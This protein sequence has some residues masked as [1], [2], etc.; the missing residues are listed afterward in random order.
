MPPVL[1]PVRSKVDGL[2]FLGLSLARRS[3]VG[4]P[5]SK[6]HQVAFDLNE[7]QDRDYNYVFS[8]NDDGWLV[9]GGEPGPPYSYKLPA[10]DSAHVE[11]M[12]IGTFNRSW[13]GVPVEEIVDVFKNSKILIPE[14]T[15]VPTAVIEND[16]FPPELE[17]RFDMERA[18]DSYDAVSELPPLPVNWQLRF[19]HNQ[20][21]RIF[22]FPSRFC[23]GPF[24]STIL[25][26]TE[27]RSENHREQYFEK[28]RLAVDRWM[29]DGP[30]PL[31]V[32]GDQ[33]MTIDANIER[34]KCPKKVV[35]GGELGSSDEFI[36]GLW[37]FS[38][39]DHVTH[40]FE[41]NFLPPYDTPAKR[42]VILDVL[43]EEWDEKTLSWKSC[44]VP[45][46]SMAYEIKKQVGH[47]TKFGFESF[48]ETLCGPVESS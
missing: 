14:I 3:E 8:S 28:C 5:D 34:I 25:R 1:D 23:P 7:V 47:G 41:P 21:F 35:T 17:V 26:K 19:I 13:G 6:T 11:L 39:R 10:P 46:D 33:R 22:H 43:S 42:K 37:L 20:L 48:F 9:G 32:V 29:I 16:D 31:A 2:A 45:I 36:S 24:H 38:D 15:V 4:H 27:F 40:L 18:S 44:D 30:K 12:R